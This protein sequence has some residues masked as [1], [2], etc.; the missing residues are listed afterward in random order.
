ML[1]R[2]SSSQSQSTLRR[3]FL[4]TVAASGAAVA[5]SPWERLIAAD[6]SDSGQRFVQLLG[7]RGRELVDAINAERN[8]HN[9][10]AVAMSARMTHVA[11]EHVTD[12]LRN[13]PDLTF[14]N[15]HSWSGRGHRGRGGR[16]IPGDPRT[17]RIMWDKPR[18]IAGYTSNGYELAAFTAGT[19]TARS[20]MN[21]WLKSTPHL[22]LIL[23][24]GIWA[25]LPWKALG[26]FYH[27]KFACAWFGKEVDA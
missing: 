3:Q 2:E 12:L 6:A 13:R 14:G 16:Y 20:A 26:A 17:Y 7:E 5:L 4:W 15:L 22:D 10:P 19:F 23:E 25:A 9:L 24:R 18:E 27:G 1:P 8:R 11:I 21:Q